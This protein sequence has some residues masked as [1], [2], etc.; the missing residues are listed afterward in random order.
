MKKILCA[1]LLLLPLFSQAAEVASERH[2]LDSKIKNLQ[3]RGVIN[4]VLKQGSTPSMV[5]YGEEKDL[6]KVIAVQ[7]GDLLRIDTGGG[8]RIGKVRAE[9][10]LTNLSSLLSESVGNS[11]AKG[12][13]GDHLELDLKGAGTL[14]FEGTYKRVNAHLN[15]VG[16]MTLNLPNNESTDLKLSGAGNASI[17]GQSKQFTVNLSGVGSLDAKEFQVNDLTLLLKGMGHASAYAK[18]NANVT[19]SGMGSASIYGNPANK[20]AKKSGMGSVQ[21]K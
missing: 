8:G 4:V 12:F 6:A 10:T 17:E 5:V 21:W 16:N 11:E 9:V 14:K 7:K 19:L 1:G 3:V 20:N 15:G 13:T 18:N 2:T